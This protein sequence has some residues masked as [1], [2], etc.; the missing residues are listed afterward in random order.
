MKEIQDKLERKRSN[1]VSPK[2][3]S[4]ET[5]LEN[6]KSESECEAGT[7]DFLSAF[8]NAAFAASA[9]KENPKEHSSPPS[10]KETIRSKRPGTGGGSW[11][12][13]HPPQKKRRLANTPEVGIGANA[14]SPHSF[15]SSMRE[16]SSN[17]PTRMRNRNQVSSVRKAS[18]VKQEEPRVV[19]IERFSRLRLK[20][21]MHIR[22]K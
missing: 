10:Q 2:G 19:A 17:I 5:E 18:L 14:S 20:Y 9:K 16:E 11:D 7:S 1:S 13:E 4:K 3:K 22:F 6:K 12:V 15:T 21:V 8:G